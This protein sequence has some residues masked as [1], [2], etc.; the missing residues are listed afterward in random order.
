MRNLDEY[1][2]IVSD[3][4]DTI[5]YGFWT[6]LM[7]HTWE[8]FQSPILSK[9][10]MLLQ[11]KLHLYKVNQKLVHMLKNTGTPLVILT[12]RAANDNT[13]E[14]LNKIL[15]RDFTIYELETDFG[16]IVKP[17]IICEFLQDYPKVIFF[18]DNKLIREETKELDV[19]VVDPV[20]MRE[21]LCQ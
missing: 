16:Y 5:I 4:D 1:D 13:I 9:V 14:M 15:D 21:K 10:L 8:I 3:I 19:D 18:E 2:L 6:D 7:H 12:V 20:P 17:Q 11:N